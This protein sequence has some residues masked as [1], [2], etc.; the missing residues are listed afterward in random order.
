MG[1]SGKHEGGRMTAPNWT[2]G[3][4]VVYRGGNFIWIGGPEYLEYVKREKYL[5]GPFGVT[6]VNCKASPDHE[7]NDARAD[8][9]A[10]LIAAAPELYSVLESL[11]NEIAKYSHIGHEGSE[12]LEKMSDA[13]AVLA[14]ARGE[15]A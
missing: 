12:L 14:K 9:N 1:N 5:A 10:H 4:W 3:P 2:P 7:Y 15:N 6:E 11:W 13:R 8:A